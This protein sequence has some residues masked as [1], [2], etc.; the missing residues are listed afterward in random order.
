MGRRARVLGVAFVVRGGGPAVLAP[1]L[2]SG[3]ESGLPGTWQT[4][5]CAG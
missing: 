2:R 5:R 4:S 3:D 1:H